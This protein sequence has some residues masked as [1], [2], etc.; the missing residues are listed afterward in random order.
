MRVSSSEGSRVVSRCS[1]RPGRSNARSWRAWT[2]RQTSIVAARA[3]AVTATGVQ[4]S[5]ASGQKRSASQVAG[6]ASAA[7]FVPHR[8]EKR[9]GRAEADRQ[10][11]PGR[12]E[13]E[14]ERRKEGGQEQRL[15]AA[16]RDATATEERCE[17]QP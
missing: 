5:G 2:K 7:K 10:A 12:Q 11:E 17:R 4:S 13:H 3:T 8:G 14:Q 16:T 9:D 6:S 1:A 15:L